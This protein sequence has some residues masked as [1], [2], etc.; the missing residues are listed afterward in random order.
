MV[1]L[2]VTVAAA[3]VIAG[4]VLLSEMMLE[5]V[6][7]PTMKLVEV[8]QGF[9]VRMCRGGWIRRR[10]RRRETKTYDIP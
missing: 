5:T 6:K 7:R 2:A 8:E 10:R 9:V 1:V 4:V 3:E